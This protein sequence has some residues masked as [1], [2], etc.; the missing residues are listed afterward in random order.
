M[1]RSKRR[2]VLYSID[3]EESL[4]TRPEVNIIPVGKTMSPID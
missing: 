2:C 1:S 4:V 3:D